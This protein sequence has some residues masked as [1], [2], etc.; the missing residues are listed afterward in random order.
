[1]TELLELVSPENPDLYC[2]TDIDPI[3]QIL[4][5]IIPAYVDLVIA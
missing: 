5:T 4:I 3:G 2:K 1:M